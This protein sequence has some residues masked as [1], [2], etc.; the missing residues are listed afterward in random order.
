MS[1]T[2]IRRFLSA[3]SRAL[4]AFDALVD[5]SMFNARRT[6]SSA[7]RSIEAASDRL[8]VS[9]ALRVLVDLACEGLTLASPGSS[10]C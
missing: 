2:R 8:H 4:L 5:S 3:A 7:W 1:R 9:G 10:W 6:V